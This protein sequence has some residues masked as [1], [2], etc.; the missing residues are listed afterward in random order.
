VSYQPHDDSQPS[1][2][3]PPPELGH[4]M[5]QP[6]PVRR[7]RLP[8]IIGGAAAFVIVVGGTAGI[9]IAAMSNSE[10]T[11]KAVAA[12]PLSAWEQE[13]QR[14]AGERDLDGDSDIAATPAAE[15]T[16]AGP[17]LSA[18]DITLRPKVTDKQ[19]FGSAGCSVTI[20]ID[21]SYRGP[22]LSP[23][24]TWAVTYEVSGDED[25]PIIGTFDITGDQYTVNE[26]SLSTKSK[27]TKVSIKVTDVEKLGI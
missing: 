27:S 15:P 6:A 12:E 20:K 10:P 17:T 4:I 13:Q 16:T 11:S 7:P 24:E 22:D 18:S 2:H 14:L 26:E 25:G 19:C 5:P 1:L 3:L 8:W 23:D 9:T 21:M